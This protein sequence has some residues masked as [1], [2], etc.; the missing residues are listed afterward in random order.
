MNKLSVNGY[1]MSYLERG[2]GETVVL[3]HGSLNDC[4]AW[5]S[6]MEPFGARHRTI[7]VSLR[8]FYP[9]PWNGKSEDFS[10]RQHADDL[11]SF[12]RNLKTGP[13]H[14]VAHSRGG[15]VALLLARDCPELVQS[16]VLADPAPFDEILPDTPEVKAEAEKRRVFVTAAL[17]RLQQDDLEGGLEIFF[18]AVGAPGN[19]KKLP[20]TAKQ[21]R[22]DNAWSLISLVA[23]AQEPYSCADA[24]KTKIPIL[25]VT[26]DK[27][28]P[29]YGMM[30]AA[31][32][33]CLERSRMVTIPN[34]S[35]GMNRENADAFNAAVLEFLNNIAQ[36]DCVRR[37]K[38]V[39][40]SS[41]TNHDNICYEF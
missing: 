20:E 11:S 33:P 26:G 23:D 6:Q 8:H 24:R 3:V 25:L 4:R 34:A 30:H 35:H 17:E 40:K 9:E 19:W 10:V 14:V 28:P 31:L 13:A 2:Q 32:Q 1:E 39:F 7:A 37:E 27:S 36:Q 5:A 21:I 15:D 18:D 22:R 12:I 16:M 41:K 29:L 38:G